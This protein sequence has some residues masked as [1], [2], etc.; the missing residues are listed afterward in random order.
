MYFVV[1]NIKHNKHTMLVHTRYTCFRVYNDYYLYAV[2]WKKNC[3][4]DFRICNNE[5]GITPYGFMVNPTFCNKIICDRDII[6]FIC[7]PSGYNY[8][9]WLYYGQSIKQ[10]WADW[11]KWLMGIWFEKRRSFFYKLPYWMHGVHIHIWGANQGR[12]W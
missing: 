4:S 8:D 5:N 3:L 9:Y 10:S 11:V 12:I 7:E 1:S 2:N 6:T